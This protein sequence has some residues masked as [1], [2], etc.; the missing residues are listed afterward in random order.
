MKC[1]N[2]FLKAHLVLHLFSVLQ[3]FSTR[4]YI[5]FDFIGELDL[6]TFQEF[7]VEKLVLSEVC[8]S[9]WLGTVFLGFGLA[10]PL[11]FLE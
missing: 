6:D 11:N 7:P 3:D 4:L 9:G 5:F 2:V 10:L 8:K 1:I